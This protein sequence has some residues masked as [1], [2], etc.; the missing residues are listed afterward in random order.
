M[1]SNDN[2]LCQIFAD[3][4]HWLD[5]AKEAEKRWGTPIPVKMAI[6][7]RESSFREDARPIRY[8]NGRPNGYLSSA[9]GFSQAIDGTWDWY[10]KDTG[11]R[12]ADRTD[13][14]DAIDFVGWYLNK[15]SE[16][17]NIPFYDARNQYFAYHDGHTGFKRGSWRYKPFLLRAAAEV[18]AQAARYQFQGSRCL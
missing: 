15:T 2:D 4:P 12:R 16:F 1:P 5:A 6:I 18:E 7:W 13:F 10:K 11:H 3:N 14:N 17:N 8:V 9:F